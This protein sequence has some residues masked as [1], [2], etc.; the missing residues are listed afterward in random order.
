[1]KNPPVWPTLTGEIAVPTHEAPSVFGAFERI[2]SQAWTPPWLRHEHIGRYQWVSQFA[3]RRTVLDAACG[4]GYGSQMLL[5]KGAAR[6]YAFDLADEALAEAR[7]RLAGSAKAIVHSA[8][9]TRLPLSNRE[10]D[11]YVSFET[12]EHVA[13]D[14]AVVAEAARVLR[15]EG[16]FVCS[17]PNRLVVS[18]GNRLESRPSNQF[19]LREY[20]RRE[21]ENLLAKRFDSVE[22]YGQSYLSGLYCRAVAGV[23]MLG[24][25]IARRL[26]QSQKVLA[27]LWRTPRFHFP[28]PLQD[29]DH[30]EVL[31][32][33]CRRSRI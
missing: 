33:V 4:I 22:W 3:Q 9:V 30:P 24:R 20:D 1:M 25:A 31:I 27:S 8:D 18:P 6:V 29:G 28:L 11:L 15:P 16:V 13:D 23:A 32:A 10:V 14:D 19:H 17:T 26:H 21:L 12:I 2:H 7:H 5:Q